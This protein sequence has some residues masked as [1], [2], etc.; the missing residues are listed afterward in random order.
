MNWITPRVVLGFIMLSP[1]VVVLK[2]HLVQGNWNIGTI[3][4]SL[5]FTAIIY[6]SRHKVIGDVE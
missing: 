4:L 5:A 6:H 3:L 2:E 1:W